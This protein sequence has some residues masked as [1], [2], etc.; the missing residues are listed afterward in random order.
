MRHVAVSLIVLTLAGCAAPPRAPIVRPAPVVAPPPPPSPAPAPLAND[1]NDWPFTPGD[2]RY[3]QQ[4]GS[5]AA[6]FSTG[7]G[8]RLTLSCDKF[9]HQVVLAGLRA[10]PVTIRTTTMTR[11]VTPTPLA[12]VSF[13]AS[14]PLLDAIAF[15]RGRFVVE[16]GG[17][18]LVLPPYA[19][20]GRVIE[21]CRG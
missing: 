6:S 14:D 18:P 17:Q 15:S 8:T 2:W 12:V 3:L 13:A 20:V 10:A 5:S 1:W 7:M 21:D 4:P 19:E 16:Q 9:S 11:N